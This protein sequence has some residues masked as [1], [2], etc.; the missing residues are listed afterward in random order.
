M[1]LFLFVDARGYNVNM[2][3]NNISKNDD[4]SKSLIVFSRDGTL[5]SVHLLH[6]LTVF[7]A[8]FVLACPILACFLVLST[9]L[10]KIVIPL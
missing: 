4:N 6:C 5:S 10:A 1:I 2:N 7:L 3:D 8:F 9:I